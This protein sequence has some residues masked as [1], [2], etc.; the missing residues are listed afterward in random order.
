MKGA[1]EALKEYFSARYSEFYE[2]ELFRR[3]GFMRRR[4]PSCGRHFWTLDPERRT[5]P[6]QPCERYGFIGSPPS[7]LRLGYVQ[8][9]RE[10]EDFFRSRGHTSVA[11]YPVVARWRPDLYFTV[12]SIVSFQRIEDSRVIFEFPANPLI[13]PQVCVRFKDL[14]NVGL[15]GKHYTSFCMVGQHSITKDGSEGGYWKDTCI[16]LDFELL[17]KR[18]RIPKHEVVFTEDV[19]LGYGAFGYSLEYF[20]RGLEL[21]NAVFTEFEGTPERYRRTEQKV[22]DMG[23]GLERFA[24]LLNG[25]PMSYE[26]AFPGVMRRILRATGLQYD[27]G[28]LSRFAVEAGLED[29]EGEVQPMALLRR[30]AGRL[31]LEAAKLQ[32]Q[33]LPLQAAY[34][35]ADHA[36]TLLFAIVDGLIPSN[37][38]GGYNLRLVLR[39][40]LSLIRR[41]RWPLDLKEV[42]LWHAEELKGM[43]PELLQGIEDVYAV[44]EAE[45]EKYAR[46]LSRVEELLGKLKG[47]ALSEE[48]LVMLYESHG[49]SPELLQEKGLL[50]EVPASF[51]SRLSERAQEGRE[52]KARGLPEGLEGLPPTRLLYYEDVGLERFSSRALKVLPGRWVVLEATAFYPEGGGQIAD[53][54]LLGGVRVVD[55]QRRGDVVLHRLAEE[56]PF[57]EGDVVE[58]LVDIARRRRIMAHHTATHILNAASRRVLGGWVWQHSALKTPEYGRLDITHFK[59]LEEEEVRRIEEEANRVVRQGLRVGVEL[60]PRPEA[61]AKYGFRIYQGGAYPGRVLRIVKIEG[62]DAEACGGTHCSSTAEVGLIKVIRTERVQDGVERL[63]YVAGEAALEQMRAQEAFI[64]EVTRALGTS[65]EKALETLRAALQRLEAREKG[66]RQAMREMGRLLAR[67]EAGLESVGRLRLYLWQGPPLPFEAY[68]SFV[69]EAIRR[70]R[71]LICV[72]AFQE[73]E[74]LRLIAGLGEEAIRSGLSARA[75]LAEA[76]RKFGGGAGGDER[77]AQ[78]GVPSSEAEPVLREIRETVISA[79]ARLEGA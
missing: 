61:E 72:V 76:A 20:V 68:S 22:I 23:A 65:Q 58:G 13:I 36:R 34:A 2:V 54:G 63:V 27:E 69:E 42:C 25:T 77:F 7:P 46:T 60:L 32:E 38:A 59:R 18:F 15:S 28:L 43:Y 55:V 50:Q 51:Y 5:C 11:R 70:A 67:A 45:E 64:R 48:R 37:M 10:I 8:A 4:C 40:A 17:T 66:L 47:E 9:W 3:E 56:P 79:A 31:G 33:V 52:A 44:I 53:T 78:G 1:K 73:G 19:W 21:G 26:S 74:G 57:K 29:W 12:A 39:R 62:Y 16:D 14:G 75:L 71:G 30:V 6:D 24:W 41:Y 49:I 35:I